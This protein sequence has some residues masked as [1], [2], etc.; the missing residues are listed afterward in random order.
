MQ[1]AVIGGSG[2]LGSHLS[3][4]LT[5]KGHNVKIFD[6]KKSKW[7]KKGQKMIIGNILNSKLLDKTIKGSQIVYNFAAISDIGYAKYKPIETAEINIVGTLNALRASKKYKI[8]KFI[9]A[10]SIYATSEEGGFYA[11]SKKAAEDYIEEFKKIFGLNYTILR[12]GSLYGERSEK[13]NAI[14]NMIYNVL[15][16]K[17]LIYPG[18]KYAARRYIHVRDAAKAC[19]KVMDK[20]YNNKY[21]TITGNKSVKIKKI[22]KIL[23][24]VFKIP[25]KKMIF[26]N[27]KYT[28][29]YNVKPTIFKQRTGKILSTGKQKEFKTSL[30]KLVI[31]ANTLNSK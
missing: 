24:T 2:F 31:D 12:F 4:V 14:N 17:K 20:K 8:K 13:S 5:Q 9:Q 22:F 29:H 19:V 1:I 23:S 18:N 11:R 27:K 7:I 15:K 28:G 6:R 16:K 10:S 26:L 3:D 25:K 30:L 21:I